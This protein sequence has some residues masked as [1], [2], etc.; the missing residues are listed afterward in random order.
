MRLEFVVGTHVS[1][2]RLSKDSE[3]SLP[4]SFVIPTFLFPSSLPLLRLPLAAP[5]SPKQSFH[6]ILIS[7]QGDQRWHLILSTTLN[8]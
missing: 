7:S 1:R 4:L 8:H 3:S 5:F 6:V 2:A